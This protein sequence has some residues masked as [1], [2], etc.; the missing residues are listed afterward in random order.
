MKVLIVESD[1]ELGS[2]WARHLER[3]GCSVTL[4]ASQSDAVDALR[5]GSVQVIVLNLVLLEGSA[6][7]VADFA[8]YRQPEARVIFVT[9]TTF[10]SDGSIFSFASNACAFLRIGTPVD[11]L[12]A[13]VEYHGG[14][15][16]ADATGGA[17]VVRH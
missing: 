11:D 17:A 10:F 7:A 2:I 14:G 6:L 13:M 15:F 5:H 1:E 4:V 9:D 16:G 3:Q 12:A 8:S